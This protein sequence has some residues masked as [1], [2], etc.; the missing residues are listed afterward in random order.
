VNDP[1]PIIFSLLSTP[2]LLSPR[3]EVLQAKKRDCNREDGV[4]FAHD[5][6]LLYICLFDVTR[7]TFFF[8]PPT[9]LARISLS[10]AQ[11]TLA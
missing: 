2:W 6:V 1:S 7:S 5:I 3:S 8:S 10:T 11:H 9:H 4:S